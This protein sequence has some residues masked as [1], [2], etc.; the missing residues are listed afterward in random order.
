MKK[1]SSVLTKKTCGLVHVIFRSIT[2]FNFSVF[3]AGADGN[4]MIE[5]RG[6]ETVLETK[7]R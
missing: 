5:N 7:E 2:S 4:L 1:S 6:K 3:K